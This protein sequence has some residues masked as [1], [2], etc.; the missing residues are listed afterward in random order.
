MSE[1]TVALGTGVNNRDEKRTGRRARFPGTPGMWRNILDAL[2]PNAAFVVGYQTVD[3]LVGVT[4]A[5][6]VGLLLAIARL[7]QRGKL[8][9]V[10]VAF[11]L[12]LLQAVSAVATGEGRGYFLPWLVFNAVMTLVFAI[13]L[14]IRRPISMRLSRFQGMTDDVSR[15]RI[16]TAMWT[17]LWAVQLVVGLVL[18]FADMVVGLGVARFA[19]GPPAVILT[20]FVSWRLLDRLR[21]EP[22][23]AHA[24]PASP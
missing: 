4:A 17:A 18:Y 19:L 14:L 15:H 1:Q 3:V 21:P 5:V 2:L 10:F 13:S 23:S 20:G 9:M 22:G 11:G 16:V 6:A 24:S 8:T 7:M 12:V